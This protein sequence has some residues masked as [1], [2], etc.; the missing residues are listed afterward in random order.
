[1]S[2]ERLCEP[3]SYRFVQDMLADETELTE[4]FGGYY[5]ETDRAPLVVVAIEPVTVR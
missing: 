1:M 5:G 2:A 4:R 3:L